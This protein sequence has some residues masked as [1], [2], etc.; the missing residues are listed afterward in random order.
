LRRIRRPGVVWG[1]PAGRRPAGRPVPT[2]SQRSLIS[3]WEILTTRLPAVL[4]DRHEGPA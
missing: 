1:R 4:S 2:L 3:V